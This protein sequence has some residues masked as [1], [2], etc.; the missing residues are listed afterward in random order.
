MR[1]WNVGQELPFLNS[2]FC[3]DFKGV[4]NMLTHFKKCMWDL[5]YKARNLYCGELGCDYFYLDKELAVCV[6]VRTRVL[7]WRWRQTGILPSFR[8]LER[9]IV[10]FLTLSFVKYWDSCVLPVTQQAEVQMLIYC[11]TAALWF[12]F[13]IRLQIPVINGLSCCSLS[14]ICSF[15]FI[16]LLMSDN[17]PGNNA[18]SRDSYLKSAVLLG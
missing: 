15:L 18:P 9:G 16:I 5:C 12:A 7:I 4:C 13:Q 11:Q 3:D 14:R 10:Y 6:C 17:D 2:C 1:K 8:P